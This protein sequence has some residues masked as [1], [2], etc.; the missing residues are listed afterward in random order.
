M[1][2]QKKILILCTNDY[3]KQPR[4]LRTIE[5]L[6]NNY[7]I[8][9]AGNSDTKEHSVDFITLASN[10]EKNKKNYWHFNKPA[11][12]RLP[13]SFFYKYIKQKQFYKPFYFEQQ[14][15]T[16]ARKIDLEN[17]KNRSFD[18][19][20]SHG[21]DTL[22]LA[23]KLADKKIPVIFNA[24]EYYPLEF[25]Q[26]KKWLET[27]GAKAS[28]L[29]ER[30]LPKCKHMFCVSN[31]IQEKFLE[32]I[33]IDSTVI[34]NAPNF[35][36]QEPKAVNPQKI[37]II[38]HGIALKERNIE[39][40]ATLINFL[41]ERYELNFMLTIADKAYYEKLKIDFK[42]IKHIN[43]LEAVPLTQL[44]TFLNQ[45]DIGYYILPPVN[46]NTTN[47]LPNKLF[48]YVQ[49]RLCLAFGPSPEMKMVIEKY[50]LGF[51]AQDY[52]P[53]SMAEKIT[54]LSIADI[55]NFKNNTHKYAQELS[56]ASNQ[57]KILKTVTEILNN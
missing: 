49:A 16:K 1:R 52:S 51:V 24:H 33:K 8:S 44:C 3:Q 30:Y 37:K 31:L 2:A 35:Y 7:H 43:F 13:I 5:A 4:V 56:A 46:F 23:V 11:F 45:F 48:E 19:I 15:W 27:E 26:D 12:I 41:D 9:V 39:N 42:H 38:H 18:L 36:E 14:Y 20:V 6:R 10:L 25:E 32:T 40:M 54:K 28:F 47:A 17:L 55:N 50:N 22:P 21:V 29:L 34:T 57:K 53:K